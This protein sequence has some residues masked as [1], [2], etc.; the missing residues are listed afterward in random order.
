MPRHV[1]DDF[2]FLPTVDSVEDEDV[3]K[4]ELWNVK[5]GPAAEAP[6]TEF[7]TEA[8]A[9]I[10]AQE[11]EPV[12]PP[13]FMESAPPLAEAPRLSIK[14]PQAP[15]KIRTFEPDAP[16]PGQSGRALWEA[17]AAENEVAAPTN[18]TP[19]ARP[20]PVMEP[21]QEIEAVV[22]RLAAPRTTPSLAFGRAPEEQ[23]F[24]PAAPAPLSPPAMPRQTEAPPKAAK[25]AQA[26]SKAPTEV[27]A[28]PEAPPADNS[29]VIKNAK[30]RALI[31]TIGVHAAVALILLLMHVPMLDFTRPEIVATSAVEELENESWKKVTTAAPQT[32]P[33]AA[34]VSPLLSTG[35]SDIAMPEVD[36]SASANDLNVGSSFGSFGAGVTSGGAGGKISFLGNTATAKHVVFV[37]DVSGSMSA[38]VTGS[39]LTRFDLLKRELAKSIGQ[40]AAGTAYQI[41]YFS[42]FAWPHDVVDSNDMRAL[43]NYEWKISPTNR[44]ISIPRY[45]Y[46]AAN[47]TNISKSKKI[48]AESNNP[49]GTN[50]GSGLL[51]ALKGS[52]KPEVI[53]FMTDGLRSDEQG[54]IDIVTQENNRGKRSIIHTTVLGTPDAAREMADLARRNGGKFTAVMGDGKILKEQDLL[55]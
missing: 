46:L 1:P 41:L 30:K 34:S 22:P 51:M 13:P 26:E 9:P 36:F 3:V 39:S 29:S 37:V 10:H 28:D 19:K 44:N 27:A 6:H 4:D 42:D 50:W 40:M 14:V 33:M 47:P 5:P 49:G 2:S 32:S 23:S 21:A 38:S 11:P 48:I 12:D 45:S 52:P 17:F 8:E 25:K 20:Q 18:V 35:L 43:N 55:R 54:W 7:Q 24:S 15:Q 16:D 53:F 31:M